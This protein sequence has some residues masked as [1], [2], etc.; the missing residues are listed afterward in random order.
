MSSRQP[1]DFERHFS[2]ID[3]SDDDA[4]FLGYDSYEEDEEE[5]IP[6]NADAANQELSLREWGT[7][8]EM[9]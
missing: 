1:D 6:M 4:P 2:D 7:H 3:E 8:R 5:D 9:A